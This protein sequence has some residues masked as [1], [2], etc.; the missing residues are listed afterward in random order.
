LTGAA[1]NSE[2]IDMALGVLIRRERLRRDLE[3]YGRVPPS[4]DE[5]GI[6]QT[7]IDWRDLADDTDWEGL[8]PR[9]AG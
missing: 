8:F 9:T 4:A 3:A 6:G 2:A 7:P 1:S 5:I